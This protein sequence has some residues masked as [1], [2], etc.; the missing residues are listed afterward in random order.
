MGILQSNDMVTLQ[1]KLSKLLSTV[2]D[3][4]SVKT[5]GETR[6]MIKKYVELYTPDVE[7]WNPRI[8]LI[9]GTL[10]SS[11][12]NGASMILRENLSYVITEF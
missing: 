7:H 3:V 10:L 4:D 2:C 9:E 12:F 1:P 6:K 5:V 11:I 8:I